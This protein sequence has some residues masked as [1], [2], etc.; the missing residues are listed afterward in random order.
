MPTV[1]TAMLQSSSGQK[2]KST[3]STSLEFL[4][5]V[6]VSDALVGVINAHL[7]VGVGLPTAGGGIASG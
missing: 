5:L 4:K 6:G 7:K 1:L 2:C 3:M